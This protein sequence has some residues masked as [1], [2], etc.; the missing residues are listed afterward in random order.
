MKR[1]FGISKLTFE[2]S[3]KIINQIEGILY[4]R[5]I[6]PLSTD[7]NDFETLTSAPLLIR[8][9]ITNIPKPS[10]VDVPENTL[11]HWQNVSKTNQVIWKKWFQYYL[12]NLQQRSEWLC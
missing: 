5:S 6:F 12:N 1:V 3:L 10:V 8:R 4:N 9:P 2:E 7:P 11:Y